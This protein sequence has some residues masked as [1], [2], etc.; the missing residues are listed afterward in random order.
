MPSGDE[1][2]RSIL[3]SRFDLE[4]AIGSFGENKNFV[5]LSHAVYNTPVEFTRLRDAVI[6]L[7]EEQ[8]QEEEEEELGTFMRKE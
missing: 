7:C 4:I 6:T 8:Q 1:S 5:R 3:R 2:V